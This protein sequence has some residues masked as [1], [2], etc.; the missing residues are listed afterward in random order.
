MSLSGGQVVLTFRPRTVAG[1]DSG[2]AGGGT[3]TFIYSSALGT[4][5]G[6]TVTFLLDLRST[7]SATIY[8]YLDGVLKAAG[9]ITLTNLIDWPGI[10]NGMSIGANL[11]GSLVAS[12]YLGSAVTSSQARVQNLIWWK[13]TKSLTTVQ[14][15]IIR[16]AQ[17]GELPREVV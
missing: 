1:S 11:N 2:G 7:S 12:E 8:A 15:A 17:T 10:T 14:R 16:H 6:R 9:A 13:T 5:A 3:N 4:T